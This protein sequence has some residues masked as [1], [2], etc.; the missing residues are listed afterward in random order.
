MR[1]V[2]GRAVRGR[3]VDPEVELAYRPAAVVPADPRVA[4]EAADGVLAAEGLDRPA[5]REGLRPGRGRRPGGGDCAATAAQRP[6][7][8][9]TK[10][11]KMLAR[12]YRM[13]FLV[14]M[15]PPSARTQTAPSR[16]ANG[17]ANARYPP[18]AIG[19]TRA[20]VEFRIL[21]PLEVSG[22]DG[23]LPLG[24][25]KQ[26]A[27]LAL[28][29]LNAGRV[30]S[31]D[32]LIDALWGESPPRTAATSLQNFVV[33]LRKLLG[34]G[35]ARHAAARLRARRRARADRPRALRAPA[36][37]GAASGRPRS[38]PRRC[39]GRSSSGAATRSPTSATSRGP[40]P[41][42]RGSTS[43]ASRRSRS[44]S[45]PSSSSGRDAELV[46]EL[47]ALVAE[48]P[49]ARAAARPADAR[50][51]PLG[52]AG[53]GARGLPEPPPR[54]RRR[55]RDRARARRSSS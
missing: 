21:G 49:A 9:R 47:E 23:P 3:D 48:H 51:L 24:G 41:R 11:R 18:P 5:V 45:T 15:A 12:W 4:E 33:A 29:L 7:R 38:V 27:V 1:R 32:R 55:A 22:D 44:G 35:D 50:A 17:C 46:G 31:T 43:C 14:V 52:P 53:R 37:R 28:L 39:G 40:R 42:S 34:A 6:V 16:P 26:R 20:P 19:V 2:D 10:V 30:V 36:R 54:A 13:S 25:Q 8:S